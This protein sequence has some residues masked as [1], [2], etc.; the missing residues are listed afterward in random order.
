M[1]VLL[2]FPKFQFRFCFSEAE[3]QL[4]LVGDAVSSMRTVETLTHNNG[5]KTT[6]IYVQ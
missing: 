3:G 2:T 6:D 4:N 1:I 5:P